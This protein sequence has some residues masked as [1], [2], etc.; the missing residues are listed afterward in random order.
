MRFRQVFASRRKAS[1]AGGTV[2]PVKPG[3]IVRVTA[4]P[5]INLLPWREAERAR[6]SWAMAG[7]LGGA[8]L[9]GVLL[10]SVAGW[11]LER[12]I[13][14]QDRRNRLLEQEALQLESRIEEARSWQAR[15]EEL[16]RRM[17]IVRHLRDS[18]PDTVRVFDALVNTLVD[19]IHY[20]RVQ[21]RGRLMQVE[22]YAASNRL[23]AALMRSLENSPQFA[24]AQLKRLRDEPLG[25][26][27][28]SPGSRFEMTFLQ[29]LPLAPDAVR[30]GPEGALS[31]SGA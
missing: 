5:A 9:A 4:R 3:R 13:E 14:A 6:R 24:S 11:S 2:P 8:L 18:R 25:D 1:G 20:G 21:R 28:G 31:P 19:G 17:Q 23:V 16:L 12:R 22:G 30:V 27:Q 29:L 15:R 26:A 10:V 7:A